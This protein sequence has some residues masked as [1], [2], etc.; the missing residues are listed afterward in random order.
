MHIGGALVELRF[1]EISSPQLSDRVIKIKV[2]EFR[3][4]IGTWENYFLGSSWVSHKTSSVSLVYPTTPIAQG[5]NKNANSNLT[6]IK[7]IK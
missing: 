1:V 4:Y 7:K 6:R 3:H 5:S 2:G